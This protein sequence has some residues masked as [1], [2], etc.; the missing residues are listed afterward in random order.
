MAEDAQP[1]AARGSVIEVAPGILHW[2]SFHSAIGSE[3]SSYCIPSAGVVIDPKLPG[4]GLE[5][6]PEPNAVLLTSGHHVRDSRRF[7]EE[8]GIPILASRQA[9]EHI[10]SDGPAVQTFGDGDEVAPGI[11]AI[12]IGELSDD[13]G[14]LHIKVGDG[15]LALADG[16]N[17]YGGGLDF[18]PDELL[19]EHPGTVKN[20][21]RRRYRRLLESAFDH[22]LFAHGEPVIGGG[23]E[24][25]KEFVSSPR[26]PGA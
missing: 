14:A 16:I 7:A 3:V 5:A 11:T 24:A 23:R 6:V 1:T 25:L 22:L 2:V 12:H 19:G 13:E 17:T 18:F 10:G 4:E 15:A 9:A 20:G 8:F 21:L 26:P